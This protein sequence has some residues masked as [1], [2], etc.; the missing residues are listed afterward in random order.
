MLRKRS[1]GRSLLV[2]SFVR[3]IDV[4]DVGRLVV[5]FLQ[6]INRAAI[7]GPQPPA[8]EAR[9][10]LPNMRAPQA[11]ARKKWTNAPNF[12]FRISALKRPRGP[13][14]RPAKARSSRPAGPLRAVLRKLLPATAGWG[15]NGGWQTRPVRT[16]SPWPLFVVKF[17]SGSVA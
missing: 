11:A 2:E 17:P 10:S 15:G 5:G 8:A 7:G 16:G 6:R 3:K 13:Q 1:A 14:L 4:A 9:S 12:E